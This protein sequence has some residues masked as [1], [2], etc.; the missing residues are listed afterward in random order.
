M[1]KYTLGLAA[2]L[3]EV[4]LL[5]DN[6]TS[7]PAIWAASVT[8]FNVHICTNPD[9]AIVCLITYVPVSGSYV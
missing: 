3:L 7:L 6:V 4:M 8:P 5:A 2:S 1:Y 9:D